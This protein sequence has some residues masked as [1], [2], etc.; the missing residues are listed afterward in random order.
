MPFSIDFWSSL[1]RLNHRFIKTGLRK[2]NI[3][4][5]RKIV[6]SYHNLTMVFVSCFYTVSAFATITIN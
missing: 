1:N 5:Q 4:L 6:N 2:K 3:G